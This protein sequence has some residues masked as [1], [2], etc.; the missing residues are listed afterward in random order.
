MATTLPVF[1]TL[2]G[3][4][5]DPPLDQTPAGFMRRIMDA[6]PGRGLAPVQVRGGWSYA[7]G[8]IVGSQPWDWLAWAPFPS[9]LDKVMVYSVAD[10]QLSY[11]SVLDG[12]TTGTSVGA[13]T[14][15]L[16]TAP[17]FHRTG[18]GGMVVLPGAGSA[19]VTQ[20]WEGSAAIANLGGTPPLADRGASWGEF[21]ILAGDL[22]TGKPQANRMWFSDAGNP[23][24]WAT[25]DKRY[26]DIPEDI[27]AVVPRGNTIFVF[28]AKGTH[29]LVG[30]LPPNPLA[31]GN[32][33]L[34]KYAF[35]QGLSDPDA[36]ALYKDF[37][38]WA[39]ANGVF[40]SDGSQP[41]DITS[42]GGISSYWPFCYSPAAGDKVSMGVY[43][44]YLV[45]SVLT[46]GNAFKRTLVFDMENNT[47]WEWS[48]I[49]ARHLLRV[50]SWL[51]TSEDLLM[52]QPSRRIARLSSVFD[53]SSV[54]DGD[55]NVPTLII[56]TGG[57]RFGALGEKRLRRG[58]LTFTGDVGPPATSVLVEGSVDV[59]IDMGAD[60]TTPPPSLFT[61]G[62]F[63]PVN[64]NQVIR[65]PLRI[66]RKG[67]MIR[68]QITGSRELR[69]YALEQEIVAY[70]DTREGDP[71]A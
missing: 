53:P 12:S 71:H 46:S 30:D 35:T 25:L 33:A 36:T 20:K 54:T 5:T 57:M 55:G 29:L 6:L 69:I 66:H 59:A 65:V 10:K 7:T 37:V 26:V 18:T 32:Q 14:T 40:R 47:W 50:P 31:A 27:V 61:L 4:A 19:S 56:R 23:E 41:A 45:V 51:G 64:A 24:A 49:V 1:T 48:N 13:T 38:F 43:R 42:L 70:D 28:G 15:A 44:Q 60:P 22:N 34:K 2:R 52:P 3:M 63:A 62:S 9:G 39:N 68:Y 11:V 67:E 58:F 17:F 8:I 21:L 16:V